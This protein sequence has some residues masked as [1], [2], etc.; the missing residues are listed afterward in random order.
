LCDQSLAYQ[1]RTGRA[2][3][4][5]RGRGAGEHSA[6]VSGKRR[7]VAPAHGTS[8]HGTKAGQSMNGILVFGQSGQVATELQRL[9]PVRA[10][11]RNA[12][13][14]ADPAACQDAILTH[15]P[16]AVINAAAYTAVDRA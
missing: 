5:Q 11:G 10:F 15:R 6:V 1:G 16:T 14:L 8:G 7:L 12:A 3:V 9:A 4:C 2:S 13:D